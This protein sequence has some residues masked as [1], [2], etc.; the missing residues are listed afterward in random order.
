MSN[1][2]LVT[3]YNFRIIRLPIENPELP[4]YKATLQA[5]RALGGEVQPGTAQQVPASDVDEQGR[6]RRLSTG[7]S[8]LD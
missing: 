4:G 5:I 7:W 1:E 2:A 3:V 8:K 6:Y